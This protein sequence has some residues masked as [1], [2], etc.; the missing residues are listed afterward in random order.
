M[1]RTD[2][3]DGGGAAAD[4]RHSRCGARLAGATIACDSVIGAVLSTLRCVEWHSAIGSS[5][6]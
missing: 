6:A 3:R 5:G 1:D 4:L 2:S